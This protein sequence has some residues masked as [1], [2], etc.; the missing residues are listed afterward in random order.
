MEREKEKE[1]DELFIEAQKINQGMIKQP[2]YP[3]TATEVIEQADRDVEKV[4]TLQ[5]LQEKKNAWR[6]N[7]GK[8]LKHFTIDLICKNIFIY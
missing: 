2:E 6:D 5:K 4:I 3:K 8:L 1:L 7:R